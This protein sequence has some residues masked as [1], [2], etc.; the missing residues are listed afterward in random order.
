M[1]A[2]IVIAE[3]ETEIRTNLKILLTLEGFTVHAVANGQEALLL[4]LEHQ[5]DLI[6][7]DVMMP[8]MT[9]HELV[10]SL[11]SNPASAHIPVVLLT[12]RADRTDVREGMNLGTD[13][14]DQAIARAIV[15]LAHSLDLSII[16]EGVKTQEQ[17]TLLQDMGCEEM[18]GYLHAKPMPS[19]DV[20]TW[21]ATRA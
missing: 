6:L 4:A 16:A 11:R 7:S 14:D 15:S 1:H 9:G 2:T 20:S 3:D 10:K 18:Q 8:A 12:A 17:H 21:M 13:P 19:H 5:P